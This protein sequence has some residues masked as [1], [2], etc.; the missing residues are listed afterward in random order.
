MAIWQVS[1]HISSGY[2]QSENALNITI[3]ADTSADVIEFLS[4]YGVD[5]IGINEVFFNIIV[6][7]RK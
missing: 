1:E 2:G 6:A 4:Q 5:V 3:E 7:K